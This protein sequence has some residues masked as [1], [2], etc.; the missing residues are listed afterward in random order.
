MS[1]PS[2]SPFLIMAIPGWLVSNGGNPGQVPAA[3]FWALKIN[4]VV[5]VSLP[6]S[7]VVM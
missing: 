7:V 6:L 2:S 4:D 3:H 5:V 1:L